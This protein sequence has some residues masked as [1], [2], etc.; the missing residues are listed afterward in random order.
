[1]RDSKQNPGLN[2]PEPNTFN[3]L[4]DLVTMTE[5]C[6]MTLYKNTV[7]DPYVTAIRKPGVNHLDLGPLHE[8]LIPHIEKLVVNPD[9]LLDLTE[10]CEDATLDRLP[11]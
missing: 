9:L 10:S 4:N 11:F 2:H 1:L 7:S 3:G 6:V 5:C 8:Q